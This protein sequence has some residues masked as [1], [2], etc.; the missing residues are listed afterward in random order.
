[1]NCAIQR[2][3]AQAQPHETERLGALLAL[4]VGVRTQL[5]VASVVA[6]AIWCLIAVNVTPIIAEPR[7]YYSN[8][9]PAVLIIKC[10]TANRAT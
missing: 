10:K 1:V 4:A 3:S 6:T 2:A 9:V 5:A 7:T 8:A